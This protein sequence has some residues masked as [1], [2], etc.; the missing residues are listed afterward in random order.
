MIFYTADP[1]FGYEPVIVQTN[2]PFSHT[3]NMDE[4]LICRWNEVVSDD[5]T[6]Y[7]LGDLG[8]HNVPFPDTQLSQLKGLST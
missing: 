3:Q 4:V 8:G 2:R 6:V 5:D 1:H 7:L